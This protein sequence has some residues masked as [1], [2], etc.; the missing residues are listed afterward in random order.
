MSIFRAWAFALAAGLA[1]LS[2]G[3]S[4]SAQ[5]E[6]S[7]RLL[8]IR[9]G[10]DW[11]LPKWVRM[12]PDAGYFG[13]GEWIRKRQELSRFRDGRL[14]IAH[15][16]VLS[17]AEANP[18]EGV[19]NWD[20]IDQKV[21]SATGTPADGFVFWIQAYGR[22][23]YT[24]W[25][26][27]RSEEKRKRIL[28]E[29]CMLPEWVI[30]K[31]KV[32]FLSNGAVAAWEPGCGYQEY[33]GLF[34]RA[35]GKRYKDHPRLIGVDMRGLDSRYGEWCWRDGPAVLHEA[36]TQTG[37][38]PD[39]LRR[40]GLQFV[41]DYLE[42]F[43]G[44]ARKLIWPN[45]EETFI[46]KRGTEF[47]Y[48]PASRD[49]WKFALAKGCGVRDGMPTA[50]YR[51][52]TPGWGCSVTDAGYL[53][54]DESYPPYRD[55]A[56]MYSENSEYRKR[57][58]PRFGPA[59]MNGIRFFIASLRV[60]QLRRSWEWVPWRV[61]DPI[62]EQLA[63]YGGESF[64]RWIEY[65]LGKRAGTAPDAWCW[66][67]EGYRAKWAGS[68]P[69]KNFERWLLQRDI[70]PD[71]NTVPTDKIDISMLKYNYPSGKGYEFHARRTDLARGGRCVYFRI[72]P[73]FL[74][75]GP[76]HVL[77]RVTYLDGPATAWRID[78]TSPRGVAASVPVETMGSGTWKTATFSIPDLQVPGT[79]LKDMDF[80]LAVTGDKDV[81]VR[82]VR[83][84]KPDR[85]ESTR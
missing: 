7:A 55:G 67:R 31:G 64:V 75:G 29:T 5:P 37:L 68:K 21:R 48:G 69:V 65:E 10:H 81:T 71:G 43:K 16:V 20:L 76:H 79:G 42:A 44:R 8:G 27:A 1:L 57:D 15:Y 19:Y 82:F 46:G 60:L 35:L 17:W 36:E 38:T 13:G 9:S 22:Y 59:T 78:Y 3:R 61:M 84:V 51:Y 18:A 6:P 24:K 54:F 73:Q 53:V 25:K 26:W 11:S 83:L 47:D 39:T 49:V 62:T 40:W 4:A 33:F 72:E 63:P 85:P 77:L 66:L 30:K 74:T 45:C 12:T 70:A 80:R 2:E 50:W 52:I 32:R 34:L 41:R 28:R 58:D 23:N 14:H 56:M